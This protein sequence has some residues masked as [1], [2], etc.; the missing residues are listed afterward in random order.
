MPDGQNRQKINTCVNDT[1]SITSLNCLS[2]SHI[3]VK[4]HFLLEIVEY[5]EYLRIYWTF[6]S[7]SM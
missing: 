7:S 5:N 1:C 3:P 6:T 4:G 2:L